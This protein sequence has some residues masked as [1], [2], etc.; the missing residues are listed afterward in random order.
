MGIGGNA[1]MPIPMPPSSAIPVAG[2]DFT[3]DKSHFCYII[4]KFD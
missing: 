4:S 3:F 1:D 2:H